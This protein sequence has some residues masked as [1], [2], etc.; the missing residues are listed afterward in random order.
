MNLKF[1]LLVTFQLLRCEMLSDDADGFI[2]VGMWLKGSNWDLL[3]PKL[4]EAFKGLKSMDD[5][6]TFEAHLN[7]PLIHDSEWESGFEE[8]LRSSKTSSNASE[9]LEPCGILLTLEKLT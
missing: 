6:T 2:K 8:G 1:G 5:Y 4:K 3:S 9:A 7:K